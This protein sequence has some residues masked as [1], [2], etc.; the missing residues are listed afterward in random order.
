VERT[1]ALPFVPVLANS[2][3]ILMLGTE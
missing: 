1:L 2:E 3:R